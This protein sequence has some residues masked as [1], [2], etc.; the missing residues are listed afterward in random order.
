VPD[1]DAA[2]SSKQNKMVTENGRWHVTVAY[3]FNQ[4]NCFPNVALLRW[5]IVYSSQLT[6]APCD[7]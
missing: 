7:K 1:D 4:V 6:A 3:I 5:G 2:A